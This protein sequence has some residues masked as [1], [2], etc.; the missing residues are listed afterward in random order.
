METVQLVRGG[1]GFVRD[2]YWADTLD[3]DLVSAAAVGVDGV[4]SYT[5]LKTLPQQNVLNYVDRKT[6]MNTTNK[7]LFI[8]ETNIK[9]N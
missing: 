9:L 3:V 8:Q 6:D 5:S 7:T 4:K 1:F 2:H